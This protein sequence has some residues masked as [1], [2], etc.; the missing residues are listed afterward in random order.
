MPEFLERSSKLD[1]LS[2]EHGKGTTVIVRLPLAGCG[3]LGQKSDNRIVTGF[4]RKRR[5]GDCDD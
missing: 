1:S 5:Q 3:R 4:R 2:S